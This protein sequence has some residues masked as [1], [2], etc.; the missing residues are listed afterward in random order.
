MRL[1]PF[2]TAPERG[3]SEAL[4]V[5]PSPS[6]LVEAYWVRATSSLSAVSFEES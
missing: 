4:A 6:L 3:P 2:R 1:E 5:V